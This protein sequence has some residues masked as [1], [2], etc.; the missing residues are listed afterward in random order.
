MRRMLLLLAIAGCGDAPRED[1]LA[2]CAPAF[3]HSYDSGTGCAAPQRCDR[4]D[5][6]AFCE[7]ERLNDPIAWLGSAWNGREIDCYEVQRAWIECNDSAS[8]ATNCDCSAE[9]DA[10]VA[11][12]PTGQ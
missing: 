1:L 12:A 8:P 11:C 9:Y 3:L 7:S 6:T 2:R 5:C 10:A 4:A